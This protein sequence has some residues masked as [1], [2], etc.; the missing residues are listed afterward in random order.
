MEW[1]GL[2]RVKDLAVSFKGLALHLLTWL[3]HLHL[4][5]APPHI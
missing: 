5:D 2:Q 4:A 3:S 1:S